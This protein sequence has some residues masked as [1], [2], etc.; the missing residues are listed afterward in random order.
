MGC[1]TILGAQARQNRRLYACDV[2][3]VRGGVGAGYVYVGG[4]RGAVESTVSVCGVGVVLLVAEYVAVSA[5]DDFVP[6]GKRIHPYDMYELMK[7]SKGQPILHESPPV[8]EDVADYMRNQV[9]SGI[10][11]ELDGEVYFQTTSEPAKTKLIV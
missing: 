6:R 11:I 1:F 7:A 10:V 8:A 2:A 9:R 3:V 5:L 4:V